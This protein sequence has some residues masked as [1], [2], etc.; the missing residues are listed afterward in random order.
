[1]KAEAIKTWVMEH[2]SDI[3]W[4][5]EQGI[6]RCP[7]PSHGGPD[8]HPSLSINVE[9]SVYHCFSEGRGGT[10]TQ[11]AA[12]LGW[13]HP[14]IAEFSTPTVSQPIASY[15]YRTADGA[16]AYVVDRFEPKNFRMRRPDGDGF[17]FNLNDVVPL[18]Y[19]LPELLAAQQSGRTIFVT[20]G[21]KDAGRLHFAGLVATTNHGGAGNWTL[22]HSQYFKEGAEVVVLPDNDQP[23]RKHALTVATQLM[24]RGCRVKIVDLPGLP[25]KGDVSDW[26]DVGNT[27]DDLATLISSLSYITIE[28][29]QTRQLSAEFEGVELLAINRT[30]LPEF[31]VDALP[32]VLKEFVRCEAEATQTPPDLAGMLCL[33]V[34]AASV[35]RNVRIQLTAGYSEPLN[36]YVGVVMAPANRKS[37]VIEDVT[38]P[39]TERERELQKE[40][41]E[42]IAR[43]T[44]RHEA[45]QLRI[46]GVKAQLRK[47][48]LTPERRLELEAEFETLSVESEQTL[49]PPFPKLITDNCT[50]ERVASLL[51]EQ[52]G[53]I[54]VFSAE[55]TVFEIV[56]GRYSKGQ[57][58]FDIF[59]KGHAGDT[60]RYDR[61]GREPILVDK[62]AIT[63][64]IT[65]QPSVLQTL[66]ECQEL[67]GKGLIARF[68]FVVPSD[69]I[70]RR[71][72]DPAPVPPA[73][74]ETYR[75]TVRAMLNIAPVIDLE[76]GETTPRWLKLSPEANQL[77]LDFARQHE[78][79]LPV[80]SELNSIQD[81]A[82]KLPGLIS[83]IAGIFHLAIHAETASPWA[84]EVSGETY[85]N[86]IRMGEYLVGHALAAYQ[87]LE[88]DPVRTLAADIIEWARKKGLLKANRRDIFNVFRHRSAI[89]NN[90][91]GL[92]A[93]LRFMDR[94]G[95]IITFKSA[96]KVRAKESTWILFN[97]QLFADCD[98]DL[99][100]PSN[101]SGAQCPQC[102][103]SDQ[104]S[105]GAENESIGEV[106]PNLYGGEI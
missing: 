19:R 102:P 14:P 58:D 66:G 65:L 76:T 8:R 29:L 70:G 93:V 99:L 24:Q 9:K 6:T 43:A 57:R 18:P 72:V 28:D 39:I 60:V 85:A 10:L 34:G 36:L 97:P 74:C 64:G 71:E 42:E 4:N 56:M 7:L 67:R 75:R 62:A 52:K 101:E 45:A 79:K 83:R 38:H 84:V 47:T 32:P 21:E 77:R 13:E 87:M 5:G 92:D 54:A 95:C 30:E 40:S 68:A 80:G 15:E 81:W 105:N 73:V 89:G 100:E 50:T 98:R 44:S 26:L 16:L 25:E 104:K 96:E 23:G 103:Q 11:L 53:R 51:G 17:A 49:I 46:E 2:F 12:E 94:H 69:F 78:K 27:I 91:A 41:K 61:Q 1:M 31:P 106:E 48:D 3:K 35:A 63:I 22:A 33:A 20:E 37:A 55:G 90:V 88:D 59:L 86:A 82:G